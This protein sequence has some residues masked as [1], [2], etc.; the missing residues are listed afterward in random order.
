MILNAGKWSTLSNQSPFGFYR[1]DLERSLF[2]SDS[3]FIWTW[4]GPT[5]CTREWSSWGLSMN[6][7]IISW[8]LKFGLSWHIVIRS[9]PS[10]TLH[11]VTLG[12]HMMGLDVSYSS[13]AL[14]SSMLPQVLLV[15]AHWSFMKKQSV[16]WNNSTFII[17][18][19][20]C[21]QKR[22]MLSKNTCSHLKA[23]LNILTRTIFWK[24]TRKFFER[25][26]MYGCLMTYKRFKFFTSNT[27]KNIFYCLKTLWTRSSCSKP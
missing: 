15:Q 14:C 20:K 3:E 26:N 12:Q 27:V 13:T 6:R 24:D 18:C 17:L 5:G 16:L 8:G 10:W 4:T 7:V 23:N 19:Q 2:T 21:S 22:F 1:T 9:S 11:C 25:K